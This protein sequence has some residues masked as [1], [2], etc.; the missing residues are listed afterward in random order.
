MCYDPGFATEITLQPIRRFDMDAAILFSDILVVPH[1]LGCNVWFEENE[2]PRLNRLDNEVKLEELGFE[3]FDKHLSPVYDAVRQIRG[4][5]PKQTALIGF[6]GLPWTLA[7]YM[8]EGRGSKE[9]RDARL[10]AIQQPSRFQALIDLLTDA[11]VRHLKNQ[12]EAG[13][14]IVQ[15]FD[16]WAGVLSPSELQKWS[17]V[18]TNLIVEKLQEHYRDVP[19]IAFP[20]GIGLSYRTFAQQTG[21]D[22]LSLDTTVDPRLSREIFD[23]HPDLCLQGNLDP[24]ALACGG[25]AM[26]SGARRIIDAWQ[27]RRFIFNLGHGVL[28]ITDPREMEKLCRYLHSVRL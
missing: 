2:G 10:F 21:V 26:L 3:T 9:W 28:P 16:S 8:I 25:D 22:A 20:R 24:V 18:P 14:Q 15:L 1:A 27:G 4:S 12:I 6:S 23:D 17:I 19:I 11:I 5:L 13:A 7:S